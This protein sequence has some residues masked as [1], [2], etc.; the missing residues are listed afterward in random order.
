MSPT[1]IPLTNYTITPMSGQEMPDERL[2][3][4]FAYWQSRGS[5]DRLPGRRDIDPIDI[6]RLL[7]NIMLLDIE[8]P[9]PRRYRFRLFGTEM[10]KLAGRD[11]TGLYT[12]DILPQLYIDYVLFLNAS[13]IQHRRAIYS[14]TLYHDEGKATNSLTYRLLMPLASNGQDV[15]M[16][17]ACQY[18]QR[19]GQTTGWEGDW[20]TVQPRTM[21]LE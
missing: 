14:E 7:P 16:I 2:R 11:A 9:G 8:P 5:A 18:F 1:A 3:G 12:E 21:L 13:V 4:L 20:R 10:A 19:R 17:L 6:P 15:D